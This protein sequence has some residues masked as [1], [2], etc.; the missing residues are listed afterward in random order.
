MDRAPKSPNRYLAVQPE[1]RQ[2]LD[3]GRPVLAL[4]STLIT[5]GMPWPR[6]LIPLTW[7]GD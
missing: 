1:V 5:H 6:N 3:A 7:W 2:A 4:E